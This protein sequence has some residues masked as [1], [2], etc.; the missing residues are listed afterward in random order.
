MIL[1]H[2]FHQPH[3]R[4]GEGVLAYMGR[5]KDEEMI[6]KKNLAQ[7]KRKEKILNVT[8]LNKM[9]SAKKRQSTTQSLWA[10][11]D[12]GNNTDRSVA[13]ANNINGW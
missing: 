10:R 8:A 13:R 11:Q 5:V 12:F 7:E 3:R 4:D 9:V 1:N 6:F 2:T